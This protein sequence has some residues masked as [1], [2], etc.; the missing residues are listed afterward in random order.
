MRHSIMIG[1]DEKEVRLPCCHTCLW[2]NADISQSH[3]SYC[4]H[5][6]IVPMTLYVLKDSDEGRHITDWIKNEENCNNDA[7]RKKA[8]ELM[9]PRLT[10]EEFISIIEQAQHSSYEQGY[11]QAKADI[12]KVLGIY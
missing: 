6:E 9:L 1:A 4:L 3:V 8:L 12:R 7:V 2:P 11:K 10:T 5:N